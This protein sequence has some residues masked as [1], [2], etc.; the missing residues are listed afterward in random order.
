[1]LSFTEVIKMLKEKNIN[2][3]SKVMVS[4]LIASINYNK[5]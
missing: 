1:M 3:I 2:I 5:R 4:D